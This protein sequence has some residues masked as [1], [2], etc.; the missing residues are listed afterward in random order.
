MWYNFRCYTFIIIISGIIGWRVSYNRN[1]KHTMLMTLSDICWVYSECIILFSL[2]S[3]AGKW[4]V[5]CFPICRRGDSSSQ[6]PSSLPKVCEH[7]WSKPGKQQAWLASDLRETWAAATDSR[8]P[9]TDHGLSSTDKKSG[10]KDFRAGP[11]ASGAS[12]AYTSLLTVC[13]ILISDISLGSVEAATLTLN[14]I[15]YLVFSPDSCWYHSS[16]SLPTCRWIKFDLAHSLGVA[17]HL[18]G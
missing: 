3:S 10:C 13:V 17:W 1:N 14:S 9:T 6:P 4:V 18:A 16:V 7:R 2:K 11:T 15:T 5:L 8:L 12:S